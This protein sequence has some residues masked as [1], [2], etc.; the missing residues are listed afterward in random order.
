MTAK[1]KKWSELT[2][3]ER[4]EKE[5]ESKKFKNGMI[6]IKGHSG[7]LSG[8][9]TGIGLAHEIGHYLLQSGRHHKHL[10]KIKRY[11]YDYVM[12][13]ELG[14][15]EKRDCGKKFLDKSVTKIRETIVNRWYK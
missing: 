15:G 2:H 7:K 1:S 10:S 12:Y 5:E 9:W 11:W 8:A 13:G 14:Y 3:K 4:R 6:V